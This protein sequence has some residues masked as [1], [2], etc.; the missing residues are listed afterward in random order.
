MIYTY[1]HCELTADGRISKHSEKIDASQWLAYLEANSERYGNLH[2]FV[3]AAWPALNQDNPLVAASI[4][5][6]IDESF[7]EHEP[8]AVFQFT[9]YCW[10]AFKNGEIPAGAWGAA[11]AQAWQTRQGN[12]LGGVALSEALV[13]RMFE[14]ADKEAL[15]RV[16]ASRKEWDNWYAGLP[17]QIEIFRGVSTGSAHQENGFSWTTDPNEAKQCAGRNVETAQQIPGVIRAS[18]A[19]TA[20]LAAFEPGQEL[21]IHPGATKSE[22]SSN[23][24]SG[25]GL[26]K[27]RQNWKK[28]QQAEQQR[29]SET[30]KQR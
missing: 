16:G 19:K 14:A 24:L 18:V 11:L 25:S 3:R 15:F 29:L 21:I 23:F 7:H 2:E 8:T 6:Q 10:Q 12:L 9:M 5:Q 4:G 20:I 13:I 1:R 30:L 17:E 22:L 27:F 28:W 26:S